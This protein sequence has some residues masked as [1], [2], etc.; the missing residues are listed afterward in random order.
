MK[1]VTNET[2]R[3]VLPDAPARQRD[4][5]EAGGVACWE[6]PLTIDTYE[7]GEPDRYPMYLDDRVY[8]GSSGTVYPLPFTERISDRAGAARWGAIHLENRVRAAHDPARARRPHPR[9]RSTRPRGYDFFYRNNV[10]KPALVG[11]A[12]PWITGGV[13]FNW[14]QH[15]R[16][17]TF[18]P[19][20]TRRSSTTTTGRSPS[21]APTTTR[22]RG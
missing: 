6:S 1:P 13:E 20:E 21:G 15:H 4:R 14:P 2:H 11:L 8:Q 16:P 9:R 10:I 7:P 3:I 5:I 19:V 18:L 17:A 12:G 22:S